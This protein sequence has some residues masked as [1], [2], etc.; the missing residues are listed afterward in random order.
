MVADARHGTQKSGWRWMQVGGGRCAPCVCDKLVAAISRRSGGWSRLLCPGAH[1]PRVVDVLA[2]APSFSRKYNNQIREEFTTSL[3]LKSFLFFWQ[4]VTKCYLLIGSDGEQSK[5][6]KLNKDLFEEISQ[7]HSQVLAA[8][9]CFLFCTVFGG[10]GF[11]ALGAS[12]WRGVLGRRI[13]YRDHNHLWLWC[14]CVCG[15]LGKILHSK[16]WNEF[17]KNKVDE[18]K[19]EMHCTVFY[20]MYCF[21]SL[22]YLS[23]ECDMT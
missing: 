22:I 5:K 15:E 2:H 17:N 14:T 8:R 6:N 9:T 4:T 10:V 16:Y 11:F 19:E 23:P 13:A 12:R 3:G 1:S 18:N 7:E 20:F 21:V